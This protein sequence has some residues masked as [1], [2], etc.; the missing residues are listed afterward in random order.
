M[1]AQTFA[2]SLSR[3]TAETL[4]RSQTATEAQPVRHTPRR[5]P[6]VASTLSRVGLAAA[7]AE[8]CNAALQSLAQLA[9]QID[10]DGRRANV[11]ADGRLLIP[12][13]MGRQGHKYYGLRR[14]ESDTLRACL[15][16][17]MTPKA[18]APLPLLVYDS[19]R[20]SWYVNVT[21][22][23]TEGAAVA[24]IQKHGISSRE[25]KRTLE[26]IQSAGNE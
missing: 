6:N 11:D 3:A 12:A 16:Q 4:A 24:Y 13:P 2:Y 9:Y 15:L 20:R 19:G 8:L 17:R 10:T 14:R 22:Y 7:S 25:Y 1:T 23:P 21:D 5:L 26:R 18:G